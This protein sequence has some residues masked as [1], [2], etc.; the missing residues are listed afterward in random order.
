MFHRVDTVFNSTTSKA[1]PG[2]Q[3]QVYDSGGSLVPIYADESGTP[4]ASVSGIANTAVT[5]DDGRY[6]FWVA[7]GTYDI[8]FFYG[9]S[10]VDTLSKIAM[11]GSATAA[12]AVKANASALGVSSSASNL[13]AF[14]TPIIA[15]NS[16]A[17][18]AL[19]QVGTVLA[20]ISDVVRS[21]T[22]FGVVQSASDQSA[23]VQAA[24]DALPSTGG[25]LSVPFVVVAKDIKINGTARDKQ[26]VVLQGLG[27]GSGFKLPNS[28]GAVNLIDGE[29][30]VNCWIQ[31]MTLDGNRANQT[32]PPLVDGPDYEKYN[33]CYFEGAADSGVRDCSFVNFEV[34]AC[35]LG[36]P[37]T[38]KTGSDRCQALD[39]RFTNCRNALTGMRMRRALVSR[40]LVR[41]TGSGTED[42]AVVVDEYSTDCQVSDNDISGTN[43][44]AI[45]LFR[46]T[47]C[48]VS[49][50]RLTNC[51]VSIGV[52]DAATDNMIIGNNCDD[53]GNS[54]IKLANGSVRNTILNNVLTDAAQ[55]NIVIELGTGASNFAVIAGNRCRGAGFS[56]IGLFSATHSL[57]EGNYCWEANGSGIYSDG[58][59]DY[60]EIIGNFC[61][62][63]SLASVNDAGIRVLNANNLLIEGNKCFDSQST[64][65]QKWGIRAN[66]GTMGT[67]TIISNDVN[68]NLTAGMTLSGTPIVKNNLG[69]K[70]ENG[71][72]VTLGAAATAVT[73]NHGLDMTPNRALVRVNFYDATV[74]ASKA[75]YIANVGPTSFEVRVDA[76]PGA[77]TE[78]TWEA[79]VQP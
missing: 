11:D 55:Y 56:N 77:D 28:A 31:G 21:V 10:L 47:D 18:A 69:W 70:T 58:P 50:N 79:K 23:L 33:G 66:E 41:E 20:P 46:A 17:K 34:I 30:A 38:G 60:S 19:E 25:T 48:I 39:N 62:N 32:V 37:W 16:T 75:A 64:K 12:V 63:N 3:V 76:A 61:Y 6:D 29:G 36:A 13:G 5:S 43:A 52:S 40:N 68:V 26:N 78:I 15:D 73:V 4:I 59:M 27:S 65:T 53:A 49:A 7:D 24:I 51:L 44:P 57:I 22:A 35:M 14:T 42:Y 71:G 1:I 9:S 54:H 45:F 74:R 72:I 2:V 67:L 8:R